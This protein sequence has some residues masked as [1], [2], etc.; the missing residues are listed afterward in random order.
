MGLITCSKCG[1]KGWIQGKTNL[2]RPECPAC[3]GSGVTW[4]SRRIPL[5]L[6]IVFGVGL[7]LLFKLT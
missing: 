6:V 4:F 5:I 1:G 2:D 7:V 3:G